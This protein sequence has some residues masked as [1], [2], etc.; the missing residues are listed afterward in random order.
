[1]AHLHQPAV[2]DVEK[3]SA[4]ADTLSH[5]VCL[6]LKFEGHD[7]FGDHGEAEFR[8]FMPKALADYARAIAAAI[9]AVPVPVTEDA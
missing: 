5:D 9:N 6:T 4:S 3:V 2:S 1:M 7:L 8:V